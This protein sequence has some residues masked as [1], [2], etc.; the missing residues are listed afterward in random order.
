M[1]RLRKAGDPEYQGLLNA[2][3]SKLLD[4]ELGTGSKYQSYREIDEV[5]PETVNIDN[6]DTVLFGLAP[7]TEVSIDDS[8]NVTGG[9]AIFDNQGRVNFDKIPFSASELSETA[10]DSVNTDKDALLKAMIYP[11]N[12]DVSGNPALAR[13][14]DM[15]LAMRSNNVPA[16]R[17]AGMPIEVS[18][19]AVRYLANKFSKGKNDQPIRS[20]SFVKGG[21][22]GDPARS[23]ILIPGTNTKFVDA[24]KEDKKA[25]LDD[26]NITLLGQWLRQGGGSIGNPSMTIVPPGKNSHMDHIQPFSGSK[27]AKGENESKYY[28][29]GLENISYLDET[30][31]VHSKLNYSNQGRHMLM[32]LADEMRRA[33]KPFPARLTRAELEDKNRERLSDEQGGI[34]L[35]TKEA[36]N[37]NDA[38]E[39]LLKMIQYLNKYGS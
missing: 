16:Y 36:T 39:E 34:R 20:S 11:D 14:V 28:S 5:F 35:I 32:Y 8:G 21:G 29:D 38:G 6:A 33:G 9:D 3:G 24:S 30:A 25:Y 37:V 10:P 18:D 7:T 15:G 22:L 4:D 26:R 23:E 31:N 12:I 2:V 19:E 27:D 1:S 17:M 13:A